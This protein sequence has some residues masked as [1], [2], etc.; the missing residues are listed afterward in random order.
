[1]KIEKTDR[2][3][4]AETLRKTFV[5]K[6]SASVLEK[7]NAIIS[8]EHWSANRQAV[9]RLGVIELGEDRLTC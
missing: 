3:R 8:T 6:S 7:L 5:G 4:S 2:P 1:M 9:R